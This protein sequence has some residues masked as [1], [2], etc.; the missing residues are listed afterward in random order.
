[1]NVTWRPYQIECKRAIKTNYDKGVTKQLIVAAT[2]VGKRL[3]ALDLAK[4]F[5]RTLFI[6]HREEL[7]QQAYEEIDQIWPMQVGIVKGPLF[8]IDKRVVVASVQTLYNR[9]D[10]IDP[11][12]F[13]LVI[14]DEAHHYVSPT[15]L[16]SVRHFNSKLLTAWTATPKRLDGLSLSNI[17]QDMVFEYR[18]QNGIKDGYLAPIDAYQ[19]KTQTDISKVKRTAG[20]F[21][22]KDLSEKVDS[23]LRN[24]LIVSKHLEYA[25]DRQGIAYC[26]DIDHCY[27]LKRLFVDRGISCEAVVS[28]TE[29]CPNRAEIVKAYS[30]GE[31]DVLTN[32][33][34]LTEGFDYPDVG[35]I[36]MG[37]PTQSETLYIQSIGRGTRL[38]SDAFKK[39]FGTDRCIVLDFVDNTGKLSLV[40]AWELEKGEKLEDRVF[41]PPEH[42]DKLIEQ[43]EKRERMIKIEPGKDKKIN[44]LTLPTLKPW[45]SEK[46]LELATEK[47]IK[48]I[49]DLGAYQEG[50]EYTKAMA[51]EIISNQPAY[52]WQIRFLAEHHYDV[53]GKVTQGQYQR[54]KWTIENRDKYKMKTS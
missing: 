5:K 30:H 9:L 52:E 28:D 31:I 38:K 46:M 27:N 19:I 10:R 54:V 51:S 22:S 42:M 49:K 18:I 39:K 16:K 13:D 17:V 15:F 20:D 33:N 43:R 47:Q 48:W 26:V 37:R 32:V 36:M 23:E 14:V 11:N 7:I 6:A 25:K 21:N 4:H 41:L 29:R 1:M 44:L 12:T 35:S 53:R 3:M 40:N 45:A 8:E 2:G 34:I 24:N 50:V